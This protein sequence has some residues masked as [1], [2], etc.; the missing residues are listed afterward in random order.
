MNWTLKTTTGPLLLV[1]LLMC[2]QQS[3]AQEQVAIVQGASGWRYHDLGQDLGTAW[4][5]R[6]FDDTTWAV[7]QAP[8]G[9]NQEGVVTTV[10]M[11][12][13]D[14][15]FLT[16]YFRHG[17][18]VADP[19]QFKFL[20]LAVRRDDGVV[21]HLNGQEVMRSNMPD[22]AIGFSTKSATSSTGADS[23]T[24]HVA[25]A[26]ISGLL[27]SGE[28]V[29]AAEVHQC[30]DSS[31]D[32][33]FDLEATLLAD[34]APAVVRGPYLQ[35][36][37]PDSAIIRWRTDLPVTGRIEYGRL[38]DTLTEVASELTESTEHAVQ[39]TGLTP[40]T[41][42]W[43]RVSTGE[44]DVLAT[45]ADHF[46]Q[47]APPPGQVEPV[48][49]WIIGD[50]GTNGEDPPHTSSNRAFEVFDAYE[51]MAG[52]RYTDLWLMLGDNAYESGTDPE[53]QKAI[54][55]VYL[56]LLRQTS[57]WP[58]IGNHD[59]KASGFDSDDQTGAYFEIF[60]LPTAGEGG[61]VPSGTEAYY[62]FDHGAV[63]FI[64]L[65]SHDTDRTVGDLT[66]C[67]DLDPGT[68]CGD[69]PMA[70]W[71]R[72]DLRVIAARANPPD[73]TIV[74]WHHP[75]YTRGSHDSDNP[76]ESGDRMIEMR[77]RFVPVLDFYGV[78]LVLT[79]HSHSYERSMLID[80]HY[81]F[82][83]CFN[84]PA[85]PA[86]DPAT[87]G[88]AVDA[89]DGDLLGD[90]AYQK[91]TE[92]LGPRE[93]A[94]YVVAGNGGKASSSAPLDHPVM[95]R[96]A[97]DYGSMI[98][99]IQG[100]RLDAQF[101]AVRKSDL[102]IGIDDR[103]TILKGPAAGQRPFFLSLD[104]T[105]VSESSAT[106]SATIDPNLA[107]RAVDVSFR[108]NPP[109]A[110]DA[111]FG[112]I[113]ETI[114]T[115]AMVAVEAQALSCGS[116]YEFQVRAQSADGPSLDSWVQPFETAACSES[117]DRIFRDGFETP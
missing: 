7:G 2:G 31:S 47:T 32:L 79:G 62:A 74:Y 111:A 82:S 98:L 4:R 16:L 22:G 69:G 77:Q 83:D 43:Y 35:Q 15:R 60:S 73:W 63:H 101:L 8:L 30:C 28:N 54:F 106:L 102:S 68:V 109:E 108:W 44:G 18:T 61:G 37:T 11:G 94:V 99:D 1:S 21:V 114:D 42:Y 12:P 78:D 46:L 64:V 6:T 3:A 58:A 100:H 112:E 84:Q 88:G 24:Y 9:D 110:A 105:A 10:Q 115:E 107:G 49:V 29:I 96:G 26:D 81:D 27:V 91:P 51:A 86:C 104:A 113:A 89:G 57:L 45:G 70:A 87:A 48:R 19:S 13:T 117:S 20:Q 52:D 25:V 80:G 39:L 50:S 5:A 23:D 71:L 67:E 95:L 65:D 56:S 14:A 40:G 17:F 72:E 116:V 34:I 92:H 93:G 41:R 59:A 36:V 103:F 97:A 55:E 75:P 90:G 85:A 53:Y 33:V 76:G 66:A 38:P